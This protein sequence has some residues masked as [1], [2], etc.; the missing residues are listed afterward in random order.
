MWFAIIACGPPV[1]PPIQATVSIEL[2]ALETPEEDCTNAENTCELYQDSWM[3]VCPAGERCLSFFNHCTE[4]VALAYQVGCNGKGEPGAPQCDCTDGPL[5]SPQGLTT[6]TL[7]NG[8]YTSCLPS[9]TPACL[10]EG[11]AVLA[12]PTTASCS[13]GTRFE[14]TT[15]NTANDYNHFDS[16]N[17]S[18]IEGYS[19]PIAVSPDLECAVDHESHDCRPLVC[20]SA[21]C[22]D[23][24]STPTTGTCP[25]G[26]SPQ[27][28]CQDT[29][30]KNVGY[31]ITFC[32]DP[33]PT[34]CQDARDCP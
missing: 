28:S 32:P 17:L 31:T 18:R 5:L 27:A 30:R 34:S 21:T 7:V 11:L 15:G 10:T 6:Y 22:E 29:F 8:D 24:Y 25:D 4:P 1:P 12:N 26:R 3:N 33:V 16:Y 9:W 13:T 19:V 23:A 14:F 20:A 2:G